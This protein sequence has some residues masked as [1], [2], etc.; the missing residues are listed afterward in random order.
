MKFA[1]FLTAVVCVFALTARAAELPALKPYKGP[2]LDLTGAIHTVGFESDR[3]T[4]ACWVP[5]MY[6]LEK[7]AGRGINVAWFNQRINPKEKPLSE[8]VGK[9]QQ[10][11][12]KMWR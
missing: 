5:S 2:Q 10:A 9:A 3:F 6:D 8:Y 12:M 7:F 1:R 11:G 4:I